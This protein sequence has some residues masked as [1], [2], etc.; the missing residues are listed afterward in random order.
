MPFLGTMVYTETP[1]I[2]DTF[3]QF[4]QESYSDEIAEFAQHYPTS[5]RSLYIDWGDLYRYNADL[6]LD[7]RSEPDTF[8][9]YAEEAL[10][11]DDLPIDTRL[12]TAHVRFQNLDS[13]TPLT[14]ISSRHIN[15]L[16]EVQGTVERVSDVR[17]KRR[18]TAFECRHCGTLTF[19]SQDTYGGRTDPDDCRGCDQNGPF[20]VNTGQSEYVDAQSLLL[21]HRPGHVTEDVE[22]S[23]VVKLEDDLTGTVTP[24]DTVT[25]TGVVTVLNGDDRTDASIADKYLDASA[26]TTDNGAYRA[27]DITTDDKQHFRELSQRPNLYKQMVE[28]VAPSVYGYEQEKL[29][30]ILQLFS[31]VTKHL[32]DETRVR[33]DIHIG[34]IGDSGT[35]KSRLLSYTERLAPRTVSV[36]GNTSSTVGLTATIKKTKSSA[37][38]W[39][40]EAGALPKADH[41][42][43]RIDNFGDLSAD[44]LRALHDVMEDQTIELNKADLNQTINA[45]AAVLAAANPKY[46]RFD[47]YEPIGEQLGFDPALLSQ[48]DLIFVETDRPDPDH[49]EAVAE[50]ILQSQ[51]AGE[52][53][54]QDA[55][56]SAD[57]LLGDDVETVVDTVTPTINPD[58]LRKYIA[59]A[60]RTCSPT[61]TDEAMQTIKDVYVDL[62]TKGVDEDA[63]VPV[64]ARKLEALVR[65]A[66]ASARV[67]LSDTVTEQDADR[68]VTL[69]RSC[70]QD[71]G[72][73]PDVGT[74]DMDIVET[75]GTKRQRDRIK[76]L[77][78]I[79]ANPADKDQSGRAEP[80]IALED[81]LERAEDLG[82]NREKAKQEIDKLKE[83]G[84]VYEPRAEYLAPVVPLDRDG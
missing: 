21:T 19:I 39:T 8:Q 74:P 6:A 77:Q 73:D 47:Q 68:A 69:L 31:G 10:H 18:E 55:G 71:L 45:R 65:L 9:E 42:V 41:G 36:S 76:T 37:N 78:Q 28:S 51:Y 84:E 61:M 83:R 17:S 62:R 33:G 70:L 20:T 82:I 34:L 80:R 15:T 13:Q 72:I 12:G 30:I 49:D 23:I 66:E 63:P 2:V 46:G 7:V 25:V 29:A 64:T 1:D 75:D 81:V 14:E 26:V 16:I 40:F 60:K 67:R 32:P 59:Y 35:A 48:F 27:L 24:G 50:H 43:V 79:I 4:Y 57:H 5:Q 53:A 22:S 56:E 54:A 44:Q 38:T 11:H 58:I 3:T 52:R